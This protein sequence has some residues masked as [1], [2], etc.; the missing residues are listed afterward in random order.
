V[1]SIG[2]VLYALVAGYLPFDEPSIPLLFGKI[3]QG[4]YTVPHFFSIELKDLISRMLNIDV[5][6]R[7]TME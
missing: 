6:G 5:V 2:V 4:H 7:I 3:R 1:W